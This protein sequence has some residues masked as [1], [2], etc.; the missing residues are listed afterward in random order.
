MIFQVVEDSEEEIV[1]LHVVEDSAVEGAETEVEGSEAA[2]EVD[3]EAVA[4][5]TEEDSAGVP[6]AVVEV[7]V[8]A[9]L[10]AAAVA[11]LVEAEADSEEEGKFSSSHTDTKVCSHGLLYW[12]ACYTQ[13]LTC[14]PCQ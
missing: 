12:F 14:E 2:I 3:F 1:G 5:E 11:L 4:V 9:D 10:R 6:A 13:S 7:S 8:V